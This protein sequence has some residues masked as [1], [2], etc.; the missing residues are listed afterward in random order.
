MKNMQILSPS[1]PFEGFL[2]KDT[3]GCSGG[4]L[5]VLYDP[6]IQAAKRGLDILA[7]LAGLVL[8]GPLLVGLAVL[9]QFDSPGP[10]LY[11]QWRLGRGGKPFRLWKF[12]TMRHP[13]GNSLAG[14]LR[15][16]PAARQ[17]WDQYQK[18]HRDP[19]LTRL[20]R[21]LRRYS[22]DELPQLVNIL[23]GEMSLVGP[24]PFMLKQ[25]EIYGSPYRDYIRLRPG[26]TGLWQVSGRNLISFHERA[27]LDQ[28]YID[29]W[30]IQLECAILWRTL[31]AVLRGDGAY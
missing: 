25:R 21:F 11:G 31:G 18:L 5:S 10:P 9:I 20:G 7:A 30:S 13:T 28:T 6:R 15:A 19:R 3:S 22:L 1:R 17:E 23:T 8:L 16:H 14:Y 27:A 29:C 24:R 26:L 2:P 4:R 12:R